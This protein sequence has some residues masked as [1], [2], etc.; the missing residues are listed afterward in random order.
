VICVKCGDDCVNNFLS[1][2]KMTRISATPSASGFTYDTEYFGVADRDNVAF[3]DTWDSILFSPWCCVI[4]KRCWI[5]IFIAINGR[6][7]Y[8][9][10]PT[11][12]F[13]ISVKGHIITVDEVHTNSSAYRKEYKNLTSY[14][15]ARTLLY[16]K[17]LLWRMPISREPT[18]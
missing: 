8:W 2:A 17:A 3:C 7:C 14:W 15:R 18:Q 10:H 9:K 6:T 16:A 1:H 11:T 5:T 12:V 4:L 13:Q